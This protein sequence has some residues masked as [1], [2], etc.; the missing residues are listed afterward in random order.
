MA[1]IAANVQVTTR[2][3]GDTILTFTDPAHRSVAVSLPAGTL[4]HLIRGL[5]EAVRRAPEA[6]S[7]L[8]PARART[9]SASK[10]QVESSNGRFEVGALAG[11]SQV[12]IAVALPGHSEVMVLLEPTEAGTILTELAKFVALVAQ[13]VGGS[14]L[15]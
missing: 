15:L 3:S 10:R 5:Q 14:G 13:N 9:G 11:L 7:T 4:P 2:K 12:S 1:I 8:A 6:L